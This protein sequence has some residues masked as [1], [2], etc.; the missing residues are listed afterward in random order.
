MPASTLRD[1]P[2]NLWGDETS[3]TMAATSIKGRGPK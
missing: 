1:I 3:K 2:F